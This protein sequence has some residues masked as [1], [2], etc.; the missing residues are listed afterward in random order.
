M[1]KDNKDLNELVENNEPNTTEET[2]AESTEATATKSDAKDK[3]KKSKK[4]CGITKFFTSRKFKKGGFSTAVIAVFVVAVIVLNMVAILATNKVSVLSIDLSEQ[5]NYN[6]TQ[7]TID[8]IETIDKEVTVTILASESDYRSANEYYNMANI[9]LKQF[10]NNNG[11]IKIEYVDLTAN[12]TYVN[13]YKDE[14]LYGGEYIVSCGDKYRVLTMD[15]LF[16][17]GYT[18]DGSTQQIVG[19]NV[20]PAVTT[21]ILNV[22]SENQIKVQF[23]DGFGDYNAEGFKNLLKQNN[24]DVSSVLT[25]TED[26][27]KS[28]QAVV[29]YTPSADLD[30]KSVEKIKKFLN[31]NGEYGKNLIYVANDMKLDTPNITALLEEWGMKLA[32]GVVAEMD[33]SKLLSPNSL[34]ISVADYSNAEYTEGLKDKTLPFVAGYIRPIEIKDNNTAKALLTTSA[35]SRLV[36]FDADENFSI[37][38]VKDNQYNVAVVGSKVSGEEGIASNVA[39]FGSA[40]AFD[41]E[42]MKIPSYN[43]GAYVINMVNKLTDN[44]DEGIAIDGK[45]LTKPNLGITTDQIYAWAIVCIGVIPVIFIILEI[46]IWVRRRNK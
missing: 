15:D 38:S 43:N 22:T 9:L 14:S 45:D 32:D 16:E 12:P 41:Q 5:Q 18:S 46:V 39:V 40:L 34:Y 8:F 35:T 36:P 19:L 20:E 28:A 27:D 29:L 21:A 2:V 24:Y 31:N 33:Y 1:N 17:I 30:D 3:N 25:L 26:I 42:A 10:H 23:I 44:Q 11:K 4:D 7:D 13:N 6:I 37:D